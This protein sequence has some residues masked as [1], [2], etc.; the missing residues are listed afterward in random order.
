MA[1][2]RLFSFLYKINQYIFFRQVKKQP[3]QRQKL[4]NIIVINAL[5]QV[6]SLFTLMCTWSPNTRVLSSTVISALFQQV[7]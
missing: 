5:T 3:S 6:Q 2:Q 4:R 1:Y 7:V